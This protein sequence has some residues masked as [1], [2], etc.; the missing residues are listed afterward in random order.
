MSFALAGVFSIAAVWAAPEGQIAYLSG[1][2]QEDLC[3][4][5]LDVA[6]GETV[7]V[8]PGTRDG[9]PRWSPDAQWLAF[10]THAGDGLSVCV[11]RPDGSER[12]ILEHQFPWNGEPR[13]APDSRRLTYTAAADTLMDQRV[14]VYDLE[15]NTETFWGGETLKS[16]LRPVWLPKLDILQAMSS[17]DQVTYQEHLD[18]DKFFAEGFASGVLMA[19]GLALRDGGCTTE[20]V[21]ITQAQATPLPGIVMGES[22]RHVE[23]MVECPRKGSFIS[24]ETNDG[25]DREVFA[26]GKRGLANLT[27]DPA[28]DWNPVWSYEGRWIAFESFRGFPKPR[29]CSRSSSRIVSIA[30]LPPGLPAASGW[31]LSRIRPAIPSCSSAIR[32]AKTCGG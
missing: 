29:A 6:S 14:A 5:V 7:R 4:V 24:F 30:G 27:N 31:L 3:V 12:R 20:P 15:N 18:V 25:G 8:G 2:E 22:L 17:S 16:A 26:L 21:L 19:L 32:A 28:A 9:A 13:W 10:L 23:W 1:T 11:V